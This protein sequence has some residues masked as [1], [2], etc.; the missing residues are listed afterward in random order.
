MHSQLQAEVQPTLNFI[1]AT[2]KI[3][4]KYFALI[5]YNQILN[6]QILPTETRI[7][8]MQI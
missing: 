8:K 4:S 6:L 7:L 1:C 3:I 2:P 5:S